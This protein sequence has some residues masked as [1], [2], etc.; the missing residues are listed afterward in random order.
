MILKIS[1][2]LTSKQSSFTR[3]KTFQKTNCPYTAQRSKTLIISDGEN[4]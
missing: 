3:P 4:A 1:I 2:I